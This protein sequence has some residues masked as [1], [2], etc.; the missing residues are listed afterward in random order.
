MAEA[1]ETGVSMY[2][3][4]LL[5]N[6]NVAEDWKERKDCRKGGLAVDDEER[7]MVDFESV[8]EVANSSSS[9]VCM[10]DDNHFV[11]TVDEFL[12]GQHIGCS[13]CFRVTVCSRYSI[14]KCDSQFPLEPVSGCDQIFLCPH[15]PGWGKKKSLTILLPPKKMR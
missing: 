2:N 10:S 8:R 5:A 3:L 13:C 14:G 15:I 4:N 12:N 11:S 6:D 7:D 9:F 1:T